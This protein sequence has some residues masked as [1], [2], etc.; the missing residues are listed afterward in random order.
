T[1]A[2]N[3]IELPEGLDTPVAY[4][5]GA[6]KSATVVLEVEVDT[7]GNVTTARVVYG[8]EPFATAAVRAAD[9]WRF[10]PARRAGKPIAVRIRYT[11]QFEP[12]P[13][14]AP[15]EDV[16]TGGAAPAKP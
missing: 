2:G 7:A 9:D 12:P 8:E 11:V 3:D 10:S 14:A 1:D 5:E 13:A 6:T 15:E 4:P 16:A